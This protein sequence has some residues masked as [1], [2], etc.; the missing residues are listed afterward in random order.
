MA[1]GVCVCVCVCVY[2]CVCTRVCAYMRERERDGKKERRQ[3]EGG[4][5][6]M[7]E[8]TAVLRPQPQSWWVSLSGRGCLSAALV[9]HGWQ[10]EVKPEK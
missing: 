10:S 7:V 2:V 9:C 4:E 6:K 3:K 5:R 1:G 8:L